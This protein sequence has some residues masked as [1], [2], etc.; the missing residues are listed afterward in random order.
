MGNAL[1]IWFAAA[2]PASS[3]G[4]VN[5]L[6]RELAGGLTRRGHAVSIW[7]ADSPGMHAAYPVF[8]LC[9]AARFLAA[10]QRPDWIIA[11][12]TDGVFCAIIS[13]LFAAKTRVALHNHGWEEKVAEVERALPPGTVITP[14]TTWRARLVRFPLLRACL[15]ACA[16]CQC[17]AIDEMRWIARRYPRRRKKLICVPNGVHAPDRPVWLDAEDPPPRFLW[18]GG[19]TWKK[20]GEYLLSLFACINALL[21]DARL[22]IIGAGAGELRRRIGKAAWAGAVEARGQTPL[23]QMAALYA[24]CP[25]LISTSRYEGGHSLAIL[26]AMAQGAVVFATGIPSTREIIRDNRTGV[27]LCGND[28]EADARRVLAAIDDTE[29]MRQIRRAASREARRR[30]WERQ[31]DRLEQ[32]LMR[33]AA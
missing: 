31:V 6:M 32:T 17:G 30:S 2:I 12:S 20:N 18:V 22:I 4:G 23:E 13:R 16:L 24:E 27:L 5:R 1:T 21:P 19:F 10:R 3:C 29:T 11:R 33:R 25:Y 14:P 7:Y 26:E 15:G 8:A 28:A 9:L